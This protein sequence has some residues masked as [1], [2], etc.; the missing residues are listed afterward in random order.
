M[1]R[2]ERRA[3]GDRGL[4]LRRARRWWGALTPLIAL[5]IS[6]Q[7]TAQSL[8][9]YR[10]H[11]DSLE[12]RWEQSRA[13]LEAAAARAS[14]VDADTISIGMLTL[15]SAREHSQVVRPSAELAWAIIQDELRSD[16]ALLAGTVL[17]L[18]TAGMKWM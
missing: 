16:T 10:N 6:Q 13:R 12:R 9:Q 7:A 15:V 11:V 4:V 2:D 17:Y 18:P 8:A 1:C 5:L 14:K 3:S